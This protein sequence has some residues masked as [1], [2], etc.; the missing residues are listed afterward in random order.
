VNWLKNLFKS[1]YSDREYWL[2]VQCDRC[3]EIIEARVDLYNHLSIQYGDGNQPNTYFC[4]KVIIG[5]KRCYRQ[6]EVLMTFDMNRRLIEQQ[7]TGGKFVT[8]EKF[9][10]N[11]E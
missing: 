2:Y 9:L 11:A 8:K 6:I 7:I 4:R 5:G 3:G 10:S 1:P